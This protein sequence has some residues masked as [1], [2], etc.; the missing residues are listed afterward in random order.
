MHLETRIWKRKDADMNFTL[1][2]KGIN[3][4]EENGKGEN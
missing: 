2:E 3:E 1:T 4:M